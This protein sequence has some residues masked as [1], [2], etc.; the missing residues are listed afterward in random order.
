[1]TSLTTFR[2]GTETVSTDPRNCTDGDV[3][4]WSYHNAS[5]MEIIKT[6][7]DGSSVSRAYDAYKRVLT[8]TD[9]RGKAWVPILFS[10]NQ[11]FRRFAAAPLATIY[12]PL[13]RLRIPFA[14]GSPAAR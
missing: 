11:G 3:T 7:A 10:S 13:R 8:E 2:A 9:A 5:G 1:M 12:R 4:T 6:Y 14:C